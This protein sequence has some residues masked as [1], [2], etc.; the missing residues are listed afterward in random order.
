[1]ANLL[2]GSWRAL[3]AEDVFSDREFA[4]ESKVTPSLNSI[5][6][7]VINNYKANIKSWWEVKS[8]ENDIKH[9]IVPKGLRIGILLALRSRFPGLMIRSDMCKHIGL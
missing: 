9:N 7:D 2:S 4:H 5:L 6:K 3:E 1:M 8:L